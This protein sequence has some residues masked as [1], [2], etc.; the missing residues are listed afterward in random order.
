MITIVFIQIFL[1][2]IFVPIISGET[3][4]DP[5]TETYVVNVKSNAT[6]LSYGYYVNI[7]IPPDASAY[8]V[9]IINYTYSIEPPEPEAPNI[10][11][12]TTLNLRCYKFAQIQLNYGGVW[13][14][15]DFEIQILRNACEYIPCENDYLADKFMEIF[16]HQ[17]GLYAVPPINFQST[18]EFDSFRGY[19]LLP[20]NKDAGY[21]L[22]SQETDYVIV[23]FEQAK[24]VVETFEEWKQQLGLKTFVITTEEIVQEYLG[25]STQTK[26]LEFLKDAF[27][28]WQMKYVLFVGGPDSI[29]PINYWV[30]NTCG[31]GPRVDYRTCDYYYS[32]LEQTEDTYSFDTLTNRSFID[33]PDF[34]LGRFPSDNLVELENLINK[35]ISYEQISVPCEWAKTNVLVSADEFS[36]VNIG[37]A[38]WKLYAPGIINETKKIL[39][40]PNNA[41]LQD[42]IDTINAG[43]GTLTIISHANPYLWSFDDDVTFDYQDVDQLTNS[44]LPVIFT[45]GCHSGKFDYE[46][47]IAVKMLTKQSGGAV[48]LIGGTTYMNVESESNIFFSAYNLGSVAHLPDANGSIGEAFF[49]YNIRDT[50]QHMIL[51]GDPSLTLAVTNYDELLDSSYPTV[52]FLINNGASTTDSLSVT[53][54]IYAV[55]PV[56]DI[57]WMEFSNDGISWTNFDYSMTKSWTLSE[58]GEIKTVYARFWR[59][60]DYEYT[61]M[62]SDT[63]L[64]EPQL[65]ISTSGSGTTNPS[66][67]SHGFAVG[68]NVSV[69]AS[70]TYGWVFSH[71]LLDSLNVGSADSYTITLNESYLLTAVFT[72]IISE[73]PEENQR[74]F[75]VL[76]V[77]ATNVET[78]QDV[79][80]DASDSYDL[81]GEIVLYKFDFGDGTNTGWIS[82]PTV[83]HHYEEVGSYEISLVVQDDGSYT[84]SS[85]S[86]IPV[87]INVIPEFSSW[88]IL[89]LLFIAPLLTIVARRKLS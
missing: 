17:D 11:Q 62:Y 10:E 27:N 79:L 63:I 58:V 7:L 46:F 70:P 13:A 87:E 38:P 5:E 35:T 86:K 88:L 81:D 82:S 9:K 54:N 42:F 43:V 65:T 31:G 20:V 83:S 6:L 71:W 2:T 74:P 68:S 1:S 32:T 8:S 21:Q 37:N 28:T 25:A 73:D 85:E 49:F 26:I 57:R 39:M 75:A 76:S 66:A 18:D 84:S 41:T 48:A 56:F 50:A 72:E 89:S 45:C 67:G 44:K 80:C 3:S 22:P 12:L 40:Y 59:E 53:L 61:Q 33:F 24:S 23:T 51:L 78:G 34:I 15:L 55:D 29:P 60:I 19:P 16:M 36:A 4:E 47:S 14:T 52:S 30:N 64:F 69:T 77:N